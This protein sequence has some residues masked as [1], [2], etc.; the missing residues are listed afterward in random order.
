MRGIYYPQGSLKGDE[1]RARENGFLYEYC[2]AHG[3]PHRPQ[4]QG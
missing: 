2:V 3:V 1:L 4:R